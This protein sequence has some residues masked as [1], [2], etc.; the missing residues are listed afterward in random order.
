MPK[1]TG[2]VVRSIHEGSIVGKA[3]VP[4]YVLVVGLALLVMIGAGVSMW[5]RAARSTPSAPRSRRWHHLASFVFAA[6]LALSAITGIAFRIGSSWLGW[7]DDGTKPDVAAPGQLARPEVARPLRPVRGGSASSTCSA[8]PRRCQGS[9]QRRR[10]S[11]RTL[12]GAHGGGTASAR[13]RQIAL[14]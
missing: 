12:P 2:A 3:F 6:P 7:S 14:V 8:A 10:A 4:V 11:S 5:R 1:E 13:A 9:D